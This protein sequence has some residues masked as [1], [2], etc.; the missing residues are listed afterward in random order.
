MAVLAFS[1]RQHR[2]LNIQQWFE[3]ARQSLGQR[4]FHENDGLVDESRM[5]EGEASTVSFET[6]VKIGPAIDFMD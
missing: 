4:H 6:A 2:C 3:I 5:K 1:E